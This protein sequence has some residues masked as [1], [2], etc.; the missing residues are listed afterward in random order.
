MN[1][2]NDQFGLD[3]IKPLE[4]VAPLPEVE[5]T[6]VYETTSFQSEPTVEPVVEQPSTQYAFMAETPAIDPVVPVT[7]EPEVSYKEEVP[8]I[9]NGYVNSYT[10]M[11]TDNVEQQP[12]VDTINEH[13]DAKVSLH[14]QSDTEIPVASNLPEE[15][16]DKA[17][18]WMLIWI[19]VGMLIV[20]IALP[21]LFELF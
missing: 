15:K 5:P 18:M 20:I 9:D 2:N 17:T 6:Q 12:T 21:Y 1:E 19:F 13:P 4:P 11:T 3:S 16:M 7:P 10:E 8:A 14:R